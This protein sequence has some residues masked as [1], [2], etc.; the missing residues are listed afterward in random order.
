MIQIHVSIS[1]YRNSC[2][3]YNLA[4]SFTVDYFVCIHPSTLLQITLQPEGFVKTV[5]AN[6]ER[7]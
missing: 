1:E 7:K 3:T 4:E 6:T 5:G 2:R